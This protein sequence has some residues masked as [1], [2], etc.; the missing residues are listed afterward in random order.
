ML[1]SILRSLSTGESL[2]ITER[3]RL[4]SVNPPHIVLDCDAVTP[5][6]M[7]QAGAWNRTMPNLAV[8][9]EKFVYQNVYSG[10]AVEP[11]HRQKMHDLIIGSQGVALNQKLSQLVDQIDRHNEQIR[12]KGN[13]I[14]SFERGLLSVDNFCNLPVDP[15]IDQKIKDAEHV[16]LIA[17]DQEAIRNAAS[18]ELLTL[19][20]IDTKSIEDMLQQDL[21]LVDSTALARVQNHLAEIGIGGESWVSDGMKRVRADSI[22]PFCAQNL[23]TSTIFTHYRAYF[24]EEYAR[25]KTEID[26]ISKEF[27]Q[28]HDGTASLRFERQ[29]NTMRER[30]EYWSK[31]IDIPS[32]SLDTKDISEVWAFAR[33]QVSDTLNS[34][35][36]AP[37]EKISLPKE[38]RR[39]IARYKRY[40]RQIIHV[41]RL[42]SAVITQIQVAKESQPSGSIGTLEAIL[43]NLKSVKARHSSA[44]DA[45]CRD[46]LVEKTSKE[47]TEQ[48]RTA[49]RTAL[50]QYRSTVFPAYEIAINR[51]LTVFNAGFSLKVK[52]V[53]IG[54]GSGSTCAYEIIINQHPVAVKGK[55]IV[56]QPSF[57]NTLSA[58]D[59]NALALAFF[60][61]SIDS[62]P[63]LDQKVVVI[64]DP[65]SSLDEHRTRTTVQEFIRLSQRT[66]QVIL[67][68]HSKPFLCATW[69]L[70]DKN[71]RT[72]LEI[73][74]QNAGSTIASWNIHQD[75]ITLHDQRHT[76]LNEYLTANNVTKQRD[77][78]T[79][80]RPHLEAFL[81]VAYPEYFPPGT[82]LG[83]F[84]AICK[85][86]ATTGN[87]ILN[88][89]DISELENLTNY[90]NLFHHDS[91]PSWQSVTINDGELC[92]FVRRILTFVKKTI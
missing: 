84:I 61:A 16:L 60:F 32:V 87:G 66:A 15:G 67:L 74:R 86:R 79:A 72:T 71:S 44:T 27:V 43:S 29:V 11:E 3:Q 49:A 57:N 24:S 34:K 23:A 9:D 19:P 54:S 45:L 55:P 90:G 14:P 70:A 38:T 25:L 89:N 75:C 7:F 17:R 2:L 69:E 68:S 88:S 30:M 28:S 5:S 50:D 59:R 39:S 20:D 1:T 85:Q 8:F 81:R 62:D 52:A 77:V 56:G 80:I 21:P 51:Y 73:K 13:A 65:I 76:L 37:L 48:R 63:T 6:T 83:P 92:G 40:I 78:A 53:S 10:L 42:L 31:Y 36:Q 35:R 64:D 12:L 18:F 26:R 33:D 22:C 82:L 4:G 46:Y 41:N 47:E 58:G 91:N